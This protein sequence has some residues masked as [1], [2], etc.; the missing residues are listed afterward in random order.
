MS[1]PV[2]GIP[3]YISGYRFNTPRP[4]GPHEGLDLRAMNRLW[5]PVNI[6]SVADGDVVYAGNMRQSNLYEPSDYG[7]YVIVEHDNGLIS[8]SCHLEYM[9]VQAGDR[10][11]QGQMLGLAGSTGKSDG[12][13][14]HL[15]IQNPGAGLAGYIIDDAL[16]PAPLLG[17]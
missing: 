7:N 9:T 4:Y 3:L 10:V 1:S 8:W 15:N 13:H 16:D 6:L 5:E 14:L 12:V 17:L 2:E 11:L